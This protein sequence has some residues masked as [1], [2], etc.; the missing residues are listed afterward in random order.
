MPLPIN[1]H[2]RLHKLESS[3]RLLLERLSIVNRRLSEVE[4]ER[5]ALL[6]QR[7]ALQE[8]NRQ[9]QQQLKEAQKKPAPVTGHFHNSGKSRKLVENYVY[10]ADNPA[11]LKDK[12]DEYIREIDQCIA[13]LSS[14]NTL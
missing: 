9:L 2:E 10:T 11:E 6:A 14:S 8:Q 12:L 13:Y 3:T 1:L 7:D 5:N 4:R